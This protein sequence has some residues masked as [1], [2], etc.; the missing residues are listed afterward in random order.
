MSCI[1]RNWS[2]FGSYNVIF[3][4]LEFPTHNFDFHLLTT[5]VNAKYYIYIYIFSKNLLVYYCKCC[6]LI[7]YATRYLF[8]NIY[9]VAASNATKP[10]FSQKKQ[11]LFLVF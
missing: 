3:T 6:N 1:F 10:S 11:C 8:V 9:Q 5:S 4:T 2:R 7:G